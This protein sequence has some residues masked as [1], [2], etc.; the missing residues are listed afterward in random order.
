MPL[1]LQCVA[2]VVVALL[3][4]SLG[5]VGVSLAQNS[6][7][8]PAADKTPANASSS[9]AAEMQ[10]TPPSRAFTQYQQSKAAGAIVTQTPDGH[11]L[12]YAPPPIDF[13]QSPAA[14][15]FAPA[16][17]PAPVL[18]AAY[19]LRSENKVSPVGDQGP[20][21]A[22]WAFA[23]FGSLESVRL[24][25][26]ST[27]L[28]ANHLK[29]LHDFDPSCCGGGNAIMSAAY[30]TRGGTI[31]KDSTGSPMFAGPVSQIGDPY[32]T[33]SCSE[34][35]RLIPLAAHVQNVYWLPS[36][37]GPMDNGV[38]K[39]ALMTYGG[40]FTSIDWE[41]SSRNSS[42]YWNNATA[43]YYDYHVSNPNHAVTIVGWDDNY[44][45][46]K[47]ATPPPGDGAWVVKN[48]WGTLWGRS[49]YFYVSYYDANFGNRENV[50]FTAEPATNY[51]TNYQYDPFGLETSWG[52]SKG[53]S[54]Y[55]ANVFSATSDG[56]LRAVSFWALAPGT[57]YTA[58]V[59]TNPTP[60]NPASGTLASTISGSTR[61]A[62]YYT[63]SL[64]AGVPLKTGEKFA[65]VVKFTRP[66]YTSS[67]PLQTAGG[68]IPAQTLVQ[69]FD[70]KVP[71][72][73]SGVSFI[74]P[75]GHSWTD[76]TWIDPY[77]AVN[78]HAFAS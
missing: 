42:Q 68:P 58:Q 61:Y 63:E 67:V 55:G 31:A 7:A 57:Q 15:A 10:K 32:K 52:K 60:N 34:S 40:V 64:K 39:S 47:F 6:R 23:T 48:S 70:S 8:T 11:G 17:A 1:R 72:T 3:L 62:G 24:P 35:S 78:V 69:G 45:K 73:P 76:I 20:C 75:D 13:S 30:L 27:L 71:A 21:G 4:G 46:T 74:S 51:K 44:A 56:T 16:F 25:A 22:C 37:Q 9:L 66:S 49:G 26:S 38:I 28:S 18:P 19:D 53:T 2:I 59:Y 36:R 12:G 14:P 54:G 29:N 33:V 77:G 41:G 43:A 5:A 65:V 50:V